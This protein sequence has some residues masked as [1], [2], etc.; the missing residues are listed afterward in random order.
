MPESIAAIIMAIK[1]GVLGVFAVLY[2]LM[3]IPMLRP[4][5]FSAVS[6][7]L[8]MVIGIIGAVAFLVLSGAGFRPGA[9]IIFGL[10][11]T[12]LGVVFGLFSTFET[13]DGIK[14]LKRSA[15]GPLML[16][17]A[18]LAAIAAGLFGTVNLAAIGA[19][20]ITFAIAMQTATGL[21]EIARASK[22]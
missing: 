1:W 20:V 10:F 19:I 17:L 14:V 12:I 6:E 5:K 9:A 8:L 7:L 18:Y 4:V 11:G 3:L 2:L 13:E 21:T 15:G 22:A 16:F